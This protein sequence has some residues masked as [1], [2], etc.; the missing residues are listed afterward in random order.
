MIRAL[1]VYLSLVCLISPMTLNGVV[2]VYLMGSGDAATDSEVSTML[3]NAGFT[4]ID[5]LEF[6]DMDGSET[7]EGVD[8]LYFQNSFNWGQDMLLSVA[9]NIES[10]VSDGG[11]LVTAEWVV[12]SVYASGDSDWSPLESLLPVDYVD[13]TSPTSVT[14]TQVSAEAQINQGVNSSFDFTP[15]DSDGS[16]TTFTLKSGA[17]NYYNATTVDGTSVGMAGW[18]YGSNG[19]RVFSF[20][21][22]MGSDE[23]SNNANL[24]QLMFNSMGWT[25]QVPEPSVYA[26]VLGSLAIL[27]ALRRRR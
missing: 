24:R 4:V 23:L 25:A 18:D 26:L 10:F 2:T 7:F 21:V 14:Y 17:T 1:S 20:N 16:F 13:Y 3:G 27:I 22:I 6:S 8:V 15:S 19:G 5:G 12:W 11:G 9:N